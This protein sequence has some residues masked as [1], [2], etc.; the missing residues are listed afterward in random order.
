MVY[1][2]SSNYND[3]D[4]DEQNEKAKMDSF[5]EEELNENNKLDIIYEFKQDIYNSPDFGAINN[6]SSYCILDA[7]ENKTFKN[8]TKYTL[9]VEESVLFDDLFT[10][11]YGTISTLEH[12]NKIK[13][14]LTGLLYVKSRF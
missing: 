5:L 12:Y 1:F 3:Y 6:L 2:L 14:Y 10:A 11:L 8:K 7:I 13:N 4:S 9:T